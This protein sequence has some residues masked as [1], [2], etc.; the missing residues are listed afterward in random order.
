MLQFKD[1]FCSLALAPWRDAR[2]PFCSSTCRFHRRNITI[3]DF[4]PNEA[5]LRPG[6]SRA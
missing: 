2:C 1:A 4:E 6:S 5:A 3:M